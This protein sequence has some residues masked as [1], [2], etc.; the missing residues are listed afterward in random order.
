MAF[1]ST[2]INTSATIVAAAGAEADYRGKAVKFDEAGNA[3]LAGAGEVAIGVGILTNSEATKANE[4]VDIQVKEIGLGLAGGAIKKG[5]ELAA[6]ADG[7]LVEATAGKFVIATALE[8]ATG[9]GVYV[10][11]QITKYMKTA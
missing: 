3:V 6:D 8:A 1:T 4:D 9:A 11:I 10:R 7:K 5:A 2:G